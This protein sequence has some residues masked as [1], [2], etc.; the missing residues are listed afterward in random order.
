MLLSRDL[1]PKGDSR[2]SLS[3]KNYC[4]LLELL[5]FIEEH[6]MS[7]DIHYYDMHDVVLKKNHLG[8]WLKVSV[9]YYT[10]LCMYVY[11]EDV[12]R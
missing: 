3:D 6:Q 12:P 9:F 8:L 4:Q 10:C 1:L 11:L 2:N 7:R 5:L